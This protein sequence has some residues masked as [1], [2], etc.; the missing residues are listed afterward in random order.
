MKYFGLTETKLYHF[1]RIFKTR[2]R[3]AEM[4]VQANPFSSLDPPLHS[5]CYEANQ[6]IYIVF[7]YLSPKC[8]PLSKMSREIG[9]Q[10]G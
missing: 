10:P 3:G 1:H 8:S 6:M 4:G 2:G 7:V 9:K 5:T